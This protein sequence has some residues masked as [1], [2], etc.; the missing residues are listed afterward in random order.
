MQENTQ[1]KLQFSQMGY[2]IIYVICYRLFL[3]FPFK[4][5]LLLSISKNCCCP[6]VKT[7]VQTSAEDGI[8]STDIFHE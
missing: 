2:I 5:K 8:L 7:S 1:R 6:S 3:F 4:E